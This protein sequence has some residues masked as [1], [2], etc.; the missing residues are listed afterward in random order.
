M[1]TEIKHYSV[2]L[3]ETIDRMEINPTG[4][5]VDMTLGLGGH[6]EAIAERLTTGRLVSFDQDEIAIENAKK[7]LDR[8]DNITFVKSNFRHIKQELAKLGINKVDGVLY[9]LGTSFYQLTDKNRGFTYHG[10][11]SLD[12]RMDLQ[13]EITAADVLNTYEEDQLSWVFKKYGDEKKSRQLAKAIVERR[14]IEEFK[15]NTQ[16]NEVIKAVKGW[17]KNKHPSKNIFQAIRIEVNNEIDVFEESLEQAIELIKIGGRVS[18]ISFH[19]IED[20]VTKNIFWQKKSQILQTPM[21][22][23]HL[24]HTPKAIYPSKEEVEENKASRSAKLRVLI[25]KQEL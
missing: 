13:G 3:K 16:L 22:N 23:I 24:F 25:K 7:R 5:Y 19:S 8:F 6:S 11:T 14:E 15:T 12:M 20:I 2:L 18:V 9:D 4:T 10:E 1:Q 17:D 21:E